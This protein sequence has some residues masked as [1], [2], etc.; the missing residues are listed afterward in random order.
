MTSVVSFWQRLLWNPWINPPWCTSA[1][2]PPCLKQAASCLTS[3]ERLENRTA[4]YCS[5]GQLYQQLNA[6]NTEIRLLTL[7]SSTEE[8]S[9]IECTLTTA[10]L[11]GNPKYTALSY[12]WGDP[13]ITG[14]INVNRTTFSATVN[15]ATALR[16]IRKN[17]GSVVLWVD[18]IC[19]L[20]RRTARSD[21]DVLRKA[22][23]RRT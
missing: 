9:T 19:K 7:L 8:T 11:K 22:L 1:T 5:T 2:Q 18:A 23:T 10:S 12:V 6:K 16:H 13:D 14:E 4:D 20:E 3:A 17:V 21:A 15:L